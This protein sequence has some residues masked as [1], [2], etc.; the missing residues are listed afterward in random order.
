MGIS[1]K[2]ISVSSETFF[3]C[4]AHNLTSCPTRVSND[5]RC[6]CPNCIRNLS[7]LVNWSFIGQRSR[8]ATGTSGNAPGPLNGIIDANIIWRAFTVHLMFHERTKW[9]VYAG[10]VASALLQSSTPHVLSKIESEVCGYSK[11]SS[12]SFQKFAKLVTSFA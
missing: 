8:D 12:N 7:T 2:I 3:R 6:R 4:A 1:Y 10:A 5:S 9:I 11:V